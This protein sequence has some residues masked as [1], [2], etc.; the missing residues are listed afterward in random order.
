M[1]IC[2]ECYLKNTYDS[3]WWDIAPKS[4]GKCEV[5]EKGDVC[6]DIHHSKIPNEKYSGT[7][8]TT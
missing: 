7:K 4:K 5:C 8:K 6:A 2:K 3:F 1:F